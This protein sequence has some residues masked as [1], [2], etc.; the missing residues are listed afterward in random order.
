MFF[1]RIA[2]LLTIACPIVGCFSEKPSI[3]CQSL[4]Q[5]AKCGDA[6]AV[7]PTAA[8]CA[9]GSILERDESIERINE[10]GSRATCGE[11]TACLSSTQG[12]ITTRAIDQAVRDA[13]ATYAGRC[14]LNS[15]DLCF[16]WTGSTPAETGIQQYYD[17][18]YLSD[19]IDCYESSFAC[20]EDATSQCFDLAEPAVCAGT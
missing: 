15:A 9:C 8:A 6:S 18:S 7:C 19:I 12:Q 2:I 3:N 4:C 11:V 16:Y 14:G 1:S 5:I 10:C 13:C 17:D 20:S